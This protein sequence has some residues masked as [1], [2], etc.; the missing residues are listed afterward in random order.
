MI[1]ALE[2]TL[3]ISNY[4]FIHLVV[5]VKDIQPVFKFLII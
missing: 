2:M 1:G 4:I 3:L 5:I